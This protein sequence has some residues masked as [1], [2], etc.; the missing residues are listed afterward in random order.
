MKNRQLIRVN[1]PFPR[2]GTTRKIPIATCVGALC[3]R[4]GGGNTYAVFGFSVSKID[5]AVGG[6]TA[7]CCVVGKRTAV[8]ARHTPK[9]SFGTACS[10]DTWIK[11]HAVGKCPEISSYYT[12]AIPSTAADSACGVTVVYGTVVFSRYATDITVAAYRAGSIA[13][14]YDVAV[15]DKTR[16][17]TN[18]VVSDYRAGNVAANDAATASFNYARYA[19]SNTTAVNIHIRQ[20]KICNCSTDNITEKSNII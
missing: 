19:A 4:L 7:E 18:K 1:C 9:I 13:V 6:H 8:V 2:R 15:V 14:V 16:Y 3:F 20:T 10:C 5:A 17:A 11:S 12:T